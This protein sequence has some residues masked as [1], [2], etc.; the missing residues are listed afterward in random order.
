ME[1]DLRIKE[2]KVITKAEVPMD[3]ESKY[4]STGM[5]STMMSNLSPRS[6]GGS[7]VSDGHSFGGGSHRSPRLTRA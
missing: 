6:D 1:V 2:P 4:R 5:Y 7:S 3:R